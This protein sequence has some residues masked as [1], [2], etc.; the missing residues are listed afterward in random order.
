MNKKI[1]IGGI[2]VVLAISGIYGYYKY[3]E[4]YPNTENAY[5]NANLISISPKVSGYIQEVAVKD[6]Q[7]V[8]KGD[9]LVT[10]DPQD[11][12]LQL[13]KTKQDLALYQQQSG[14]AKAALDKAKSDYKFANDMAIR[15]TKLYNEHAGS[16]QDM[17]K[18]QNQ[19]DSAKQG[20]S[21]ATAQ[22]NAAQTQIQLAQTGVQNAEN[23]SGYTQIR[24]P[25]DGYVSNMNI[26]VGE[27][28][29]NGQK[30]FGLVDDKNWWVDVNLKETQLKRIKQGQKAT[31]KL[32]MYDH[33]YTGTVQ[34]ISYASGNTFSLLPAQNATGN[35]VKVV[36]RFT[37]RVKLDNDKEFPLRVGASS[38]VT[39]DTNSK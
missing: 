25:F 26:Q 12:S 30:L 9:L 39:I 22:Y 3:N 24:A 36:Q 21:Q 16:L 14:T 33:K 23:N 13:T 18:Y 28:V 32:D 19:A 35:W 10:I 8:H 7:L 5:V 37:V 2:V 38:S 11:Y 20:L 27:L 4:E 29:S 6:N 15:Y 34:S 1:I 17:Q 31:V